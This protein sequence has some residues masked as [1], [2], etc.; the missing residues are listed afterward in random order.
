MAKLKL[1][2]TF[3]D[4]IDCIIA[5]TAIE[6]NAPPN[7]KMVHCIGSETLFQKNK[8]YASAWD[9][10]FLHCDGNGFATTCIAQARHQGPGSKTLWLSNPAPFYQEFDPILTP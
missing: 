2:Y 1:T 4:F 7:S 6:N 8:S 3:P 9:L 10:F 5:Q